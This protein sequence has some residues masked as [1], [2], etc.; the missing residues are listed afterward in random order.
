MTYDVTKFGLSAWQLQGNQLF[1][2]MLLDQSRC[3]TYITPSS[4]TRFYSGFLPLEVK[5]IAPHTACP[6]YLD[7]GQSRHPS[8]VCTPM[9]LEEVANRELS[10]SQISKLGSKHSYCCQANKHV[11][12]NMDGTLAE[13]LERVRSRYHWLR[14]SFSGNNHLRPISKAYDILHSTIGTLQGVVTVLQAIC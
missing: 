1:P 13:G 9:S 12:Q 11:D 6:L 8:E 2:Q 4:S 3:M 5:E 14:S 7:L 10:Q